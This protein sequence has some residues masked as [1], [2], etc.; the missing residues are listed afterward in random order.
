MRQ[1][2]K[3]RK[4]ENSLAVN[5]IFI[6]PIDEIESCRNILP[7]PSINPSRFPVREGFL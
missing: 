7:V 1:S 2:V 4:S 6:Q 5:G 3:I